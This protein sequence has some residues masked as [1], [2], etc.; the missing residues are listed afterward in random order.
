VIVSTS[1]VSLPDLTREIAGLL[2][3]YLPGVS[4]GSAA[5][6]EG[7]SCWINAWKALLTAAGHERN[8]K[9]ALHEEGDSALA[10]Q[11]TL[12]WKHGDGVMGAFLSG[13]GDRQELE[14]RF[15]SLEII[16]SPLKTIIYSCVKWQ[17]AVLEQLGAALLRYPHH[18]EGEQYLALNLLGSEQKMAAHAIV[19]PRDGNLDAGD[20]ERLQALPGSPFAWGNRQRGSH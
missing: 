12:F 4:T 15:Q 7:R 5:L 19:I 17:D 3:E 2:P 11:L 20:L 14:R 6:T 8:M 9:I 16:K 13:W 1:A 18:I 10:R